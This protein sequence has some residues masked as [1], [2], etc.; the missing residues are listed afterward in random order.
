M[1]SVKKALHLTSLVRLKSP[2]ISTNIAPRGSE[3]ENN[4]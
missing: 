3:Y 4:L 1:C 2:Y